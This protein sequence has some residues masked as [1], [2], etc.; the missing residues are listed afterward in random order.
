[1]PYNTRME[2][3]A[4]AEYMRELS[5]IEPLTKHEETT[6]LEK[7]R[8]QLERSNANLSKEGQLKASFR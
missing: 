3:N 8:E 1:M 6:L 2:M 5:T 7:L 4:V